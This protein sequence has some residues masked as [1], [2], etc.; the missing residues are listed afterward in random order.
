MTAINPLVTRFT[1]FLEM[2]T[3]GFAKNMQGDFANIQ[4]FFK[5]AG[6]AAAGW[7]AILGRIFE[8][9]KGMIKA[10][11]GPGTG[12]QLLL[13]FFNQGTTGF[14]N[15][16]GAAGEYAR[17]QHFL[18][19]ATNLKAMLESL[20]KIFSFMTDLGT[21]PAVASFWNT[22]S[23]LGE[24]LGV[25]FESI[26]GSS[27]ELARLLVTIVEIVSTFADADQLNTYMKVLSDI[28]AILG[29]IAAA[30]APV[31]ALFGK[32]VGL[33]GAIITITLLLKKV[34]ML[35][36]GVYIAYTKVIAV[37]NI[38]MKAKRVIDMAAIATE[39]VKNAALAKGVTLTNAQVA[40]TMREKVAMRL[41]AITKA[42]N[43]AGNVA[44][45][46]T[47]G[48]AVGPVG[49]LGVAVL[50]ATWPLVAIVAA[51]AL[52]AAGLVILIGHMN[53]VKADN[54]KKAGKEID[55]SFANTKDQAIGAANAQGQWTSALQ[56][57]GGAASDSIKDIKSVGKALNETAKVAYTTTG[58]ITYHSRAYYEAKEAMNVYMGSL[59]K[60]AKK[61]L[62][63]AQRQFRNMIVSSG[64]NRKAT[65]EAILANKD[66]V[67]SLEKQAKAMGDTIM[68]ADGT[69]N[70]MKAVDYA[71]GEGSFV[72]QQ[73]ILEQKKFAETFKNAAATFI[74]SDEA[75]QKATKNG[76]LNI[77]S[78]V[79]QMKSQGR[80]L[81]DWRTNLAKLN[82]LFTDKK[83]LQDIIAK[84]SA[85]ADL[86]ATLAEGGEV[87]VRKYQEAQGVITAAKEDADAYVKAYSNMGAV[88]KA[89]SN[90]GGTSAR[91]LGESARAM[92]AQG[93]SVMEIVDKIGLS[94]K[95]LLDA[96]KGLKGQD[97]AQSV[98]IS[99]SWDK[100]SLNKAKG[101]LDEALGVQEWVIKTGEKTK[102]DGGQVLDY[103]KNNVVSSTYRDGGAI[104][105]A[106]GGLVARIVKYLLEG[107]AVAIAAF[108][109]PGKTMKYGEVAMIALTATATFAILDI[110][111]PSVGSSARTGAGFGIGA[112]MVGFPA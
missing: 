54:I 43:A 56:V 21:D 29:G 48:A 28:F 89:I 87:A 17:K 20:G 31:F 106:M 99:A 85:G 69:V 86:V 78:Y 39:K 45:G 49:A 57:H 83:A 6:D 107:L 30:L 97:L 103:T 12:G 63:E 74:D 77:D 60:L 81:T 18:A 34:T 40:A 59:A 61:N 90:R 1:S 84:G 110:Y 104:K 108:V 16:D 38:A 80:A 73:A 102:K 98:N 109:I 51:I 101:Q 71:I 19:S 2:K 3:T 96:Q 52:V 4:G 24:P 7:G 15:L 10:N 66:M 32:Y 72:R 67:K 37:I 11:V 58:S 44:L 93:A 36:Y 13:D 23:E 79:K 100:D 76:K 27:D 105:R 26:S 82:N 68:N 95:E 5:Q 33:I 94:E 64:M 65:E 88:Y 70:A 14:R 22:L 75:I 47:S 111:A 41:A 92:E 35:T 112:G 46:V 25:I 50:T 62:P 8:K 91:F 42:A 9:F 53:A 55:K